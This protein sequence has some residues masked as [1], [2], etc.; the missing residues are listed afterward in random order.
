M[1]QLKL[2]SFR[3]VI[4]VTLITLKEELFRY[5][6]TYLD[7]FSFRYQG[8]LNIKISNALVTQ[9]ALSYL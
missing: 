9:P 5:E 1:V 8:V 3:F 7:L 6:G 4:L 2:S